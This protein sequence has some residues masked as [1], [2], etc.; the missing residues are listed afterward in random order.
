MKQLNLR[1]FSA[2]IVTAAAV[3]AWS[4]TC[5]TRDDIPDQTRSA[6]ENAAQQT[7][8]QAIRGNESGLRASIAPSQQSNANGIV[9]GA[10]DNK[11]ALEGSRPQLRTSFLLDTGPSPSPDGRF[12]CGV[13]GASGMNA[14][15]AAFYLPGLEAGKYAVVIEDL[16]GSKGPYSLTTIFQDAGGWKLAGL[17]IYAQS[18]LGHDGIWYLKQARE[19][20]SKG[21]THNA[22]LYYVE[23]WELL[24]PVRFMETT[25]LGNIIKELNAVQPKDVPAGNKAVSYSA[26]GKT[27]NITEI[28]VYPTDKSFDLSIKYSVPSTGD[29]ATTAADARNLA[30]AYVAQYPELKDA[31]NNV[32]AH[33]IDPNGGDVPGVV[34]LK[35]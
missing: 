19:Y 22:W 28:S 18:A 31:F 20:K 10:S 21:Q 5:Q 16:V 23:S 3:S 7:V 27:Y 34:T 12:F 8:E 35:K 9:A 33:A 29:F 30:S 25:L 6:I 2:L 14:N 17:Y 15:G 13:F 11:A 4:Q 1:F 24:K 26:N 32:W